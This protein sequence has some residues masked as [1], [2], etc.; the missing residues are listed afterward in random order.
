MLTYNVEK[1]M[2]TEG[3]PSQVLD[4]LGGRCLRDDAF[5][6]RRAPPVIAEEAVSFHTSPMAEVPV[7]RR[8]FMLCTSCFL[9]EIAGLALTAAHADNR[10]MRMPAA[11][12]DG[13]ADVV[14]LPIVTSMTM[15]KP[16]RAEEV[17]QKACETS[18]STDL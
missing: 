6:S 9:S 4:V 8:P 17:L 16:S 2:C 13:H 3:A 11:R 18:Q 12:H 15:M 5:S 1:Q 14:A 7:R 10:A